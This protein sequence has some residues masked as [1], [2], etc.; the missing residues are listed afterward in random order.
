M[1]GA[2]ESVLMGFD[3]FRGYTEH[4]AR[5]ILDAG[6]LLTLET[7]EV[8]F[9]EGGQPDG[10]VLVLDGEMEVYVARDG[11]EVI[12]NRVGAG[13]MI[14]ELAVL[15]EAPRAASVRAAE[16]ATVLQWD[17]GQ[18]RRLLLRDARLANAVFGAALKMV[19]EKQQALIEELVTQRH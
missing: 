11:R 2:Y 12:L 16:A 9:R 4:G 6:R 1:A 8:L 18:F 3:L 10:V 5:S 14:G 19:L 13:M 7:G 15:C 17:S